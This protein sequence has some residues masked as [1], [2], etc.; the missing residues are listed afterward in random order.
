MLGYTSFF[1]APSDRRAPGRTR[2][3]RIGT[4]ANFARALFHPRPVH[5]PAPCPGLA[6]IGGAEPVTFLPRLARTV[7]DQRRIGKDLRTYRVGM[8]RKMEVLEEKFERPKDFDLATWWAASLERFERDLRPTSARLRLSPIGCARLGE[9]GAYTAAAVAG[10]GEQD[11]RGWRELT[12]P[13]EN[14]EQAALLLIGLGP[15]VEV[16]TRPGWL[17]KSPNAPWLSPHV[18]VNRQVNGP[19]CIRMPFRSPSS[20][21]RLLSLADLTTRKAVTRQSLV[22]WALFDYLIGNFDAHGKNVSY[23]CH[24]SGRDIAPY[25]DLVSAGCCQKRC[26]TSC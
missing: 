26:G 14:L 3:H 6:A 20:F 22:R 18:C 16:S 24:P 7:N 15:E 17:P 9:R 11:T 13:I 19:A 4:V 8:I 21:E 23:F 10:A 25:Y 12:L 1:L 2:A 5:V